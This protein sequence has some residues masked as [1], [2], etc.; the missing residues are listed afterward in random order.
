MLIKVRLVA[1]IIWDL[2]DLIDQ[3]VEMEMEMEGISK[4]ME[5]SL[6]W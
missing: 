2:V 5:V 4:G 1:A 3:R 6:K